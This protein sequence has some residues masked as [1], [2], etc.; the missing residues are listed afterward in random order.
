LTSVKEEEMA[1]TTSY[2]TGGDEIKQPT[3]I[4]SIL[5]GQERGKRFDLRGPRFTIGKS[6]G[7]DIVLS[8]PALGDTH[9][10]LLLGHGWARV[11]DVGTAEGVRVNGRVVSHEAALLNGAQIE[12]GGVVLSFARPEAPEQQIDN[13]ADMPPPKPSKVPDTDSGPASHDAPVISTGTPIVST[14]MNPEPIRRVGMRRSPWLA[15]VVSWVIV[16]GVASMAMWVGSTLLEDRTR[17]PSLRPL[18]KEST[19]G[20]SAD[21]RKQKIESLKRKS[22]REFMDREHGTYRQPPIQVVDTTRKHF[23]DGMAKFWSGDLVGSLSVF[24]EIER[25]YPDFKPPFGEEM[26][27]IIQKIS[28]KIKYRGFIGRAVTIVSDSFATRGEVEQVLLNLRTI[29]LID[30]DYGPSAD[31]IRQELERRMDSKSWK[32]GKTDSPLEGVAPESSP[33]GSD[34]GAPLAEPAHDKQVLSS[35]TSQND[36]PRS[37]EVAVFSTEVMS[38]GRA[39]YEQGEFGKSSKVFSAFAAQPNQNADVKDKA[40]FLKRKVK[41]FGIAYEL[42]QA[43]FELSAADEAIKHLK[44]ALAIDSQL[45]I[46]YQ[47]KI[48]GQLGKSY[49]SRTQ[50]LISNGDLKKASA[51]SEK[52]KSYSSKLPIWSKLD[53]QLEGLSEEQLGEAKTKL[54]SDPIVA[55]RLLKDVVASSPQESSSYQDAASLLLAMDHVD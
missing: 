8:D 24:E 40:E 39:L 11:Q 18:E 41:A 19:A 13:P 42:G 30:R 23:D 5:F 45:F 54:D 7:S 47:K 43:A 49:A 31:V 9:A 50:S 12:I 20:P 26:K 10:I 52:G 2:R 29:P 16:L 37:E 53:A 6:E 4:L 44:T 1:D 3:A 35:A 36:L 55:R 27:D 21:A 32:S 17:L 14:P 46:Y 51:A 34:E 22:V 33:S 28:D 25:D 38:K 48:M 15:K